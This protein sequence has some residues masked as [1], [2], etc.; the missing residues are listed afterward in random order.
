MEA[1]R[2][3]DRTPVAETKSEFLEEMNSRFDAMERL[4]I[5]G[6]WGLFGTMVVGFLSL[7]LDLFL[8]QA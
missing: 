2:E 1:V 5:R 6:G 4:I 3:V 7:V 8:T